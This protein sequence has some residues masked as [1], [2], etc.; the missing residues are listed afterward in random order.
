MNKRI[1]R[2]YRE[3]V[4]I[5]CIERVYRVGISRGCINRVYQEGVS[6]GISRGC[7]LVHTAVGSDEI[8][9][10]AAVELL[11]HMHTRGCRDLRIQ[12][13]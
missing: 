11:Q 3:G 1:E 2:V 13:W 6:E 5:G 8:I 7:T 4:S 9:E 10:H 12:H